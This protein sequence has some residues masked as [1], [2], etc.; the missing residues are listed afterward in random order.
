MVVK[1]WKKIEKTK[2]GS[3]WLKGNIGVGFH[4]VSL[5]GYSYIVAKVGTETPYT[6][7]KVLKYDVGLTKSK[8]Q[9][10]V[11]EYMKHDGKIKEVV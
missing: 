1:D 7:K 9:R 11:K 10:F 5:N 8:A 3:T 6:I 4:Q 2:Y